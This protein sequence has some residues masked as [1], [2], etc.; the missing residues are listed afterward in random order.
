M[1]SP[2]FL[3]PGQRIQQYN[4]SVTNNEGVEHHMLDT[5]LV[6]P[7]ITLSFPKTSSLLQ[8]N[9][10]TMLSCMPTIT[11]GISPV[12]GPMLEPMQTFNITDR[13]WAFPSGKL[14]QVGN[15]PNIAIELTTDYTCNDLSVS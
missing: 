11:F 8:F 3:W 5:S 4:I 12:D 2:P 6:N 1:W 13:E 14:S 7:I 10:Q 15:G 9:T